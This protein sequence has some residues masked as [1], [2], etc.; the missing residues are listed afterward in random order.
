[1]TDEWNIPL[2]ILLAVI[3]YACLYI[4]KGIQKY[5]IVGFT[6]D[7]ATKGEKEKHTGVWAGG[8]ALTGSFMAIH[9]FALDFAP[10]SVIAPFEGLGLL[11]L[12]F[13]SY[14]ILKEPIDRVKS[15]G[16]SLIVAGLILTAIFMPGPEAKPNFEYW[17]AQGWIF[18][19]ISLCVIMGFFTII[20]LYS[21]FNN[22]RAAGIIFG[23]F[24]GAFMCFQTLTKR[25]TWI[26]EYGYF[27][28]IMFGFAA[29]TL[30]MTNFGFLKAD[31][32][33]VV[34]SFTAMSILLPTVIAIFTFNEQ[35]KILQWIGIAIIVVG[36][37]LLTAFSPEGAT[38]KTENSDSN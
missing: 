28:F 29:A 13:F 1:M 37:F 22:Y 24:A 21:K 6:A 36:I 8:L 10:I 27:L 17:Y 25:I 7:G 31:A 34:P 18:F 26:P 4:G 15:Y 30:I 20:G 38:E 32:V 23:S 14:F 9:L 19:L 33:V 11:I 16:I 12:C 5:A 2:G 3:A 35:V